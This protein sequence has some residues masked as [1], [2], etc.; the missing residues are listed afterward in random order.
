[1]SERLIV[2]VTFDNLGEVTELARGEWP[3]DQPLGRH[4][5]VTRALPRILGLLAELD[6]RATFFVEGLN[7]KLYPETLM[8]IAGAGHEIGYHGW[9]H[10]E[11]A[12]LGRG[13]EAELLERG[14]RALDQLG[15]RPVGFRPPGGGL[16]RSSIDLLGE[17]GFT[18]CSP[19][20][21]GVSVVDGV[22]ILPFGWPMVD[23]YHYL[24]RF[25]ARREHDGRPGA[26]ASPAQFAEDLRAALDA[27]VAHGGHLSAVFHPFLTE[28]DERFDVLRGFLHAVRALVDD[29]RAWCTPSRDV[30]QQIGQAA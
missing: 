10:E 27:A 5:S 26:A 4:F 14:V 25:A 15:V 6:L 9:R 18:H 2:T 19:A 28:P 7:T 30:A 3:D 12:Q 23:A 8:Q 21:T 13:Q 1:M 29:G 16:T 20:G 11:W 24:P 17:L 22:T